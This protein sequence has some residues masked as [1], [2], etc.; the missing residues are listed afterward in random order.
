VK[1]CDDCG[2]E[3]RRRKRCWQ[4]GQFVCSWCW[5]HEHA[6]EPG[7]SRAECEDLER[8]E[9]LIRPLG[10]AAVRSYF[11]RLRYLSMVSGQ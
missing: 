5:H 6:C 9:T 10:P 4:C 1:E 7:H 8:L 3:A 2:R 11:D